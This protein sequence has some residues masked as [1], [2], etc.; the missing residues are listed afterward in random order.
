[1]FIASGLASASVL[2]ILNKDHL[3][4]DSTALNFLTRFLKAYLQTESIDHLSSSLRKGGVAD[5]MQFFPPARQSMA[6]LSAH[7]KAE[8]LQNV[9]D[10]Y[11]KQKSGQAKEETLFK[12][13]EMV[14]DE[15]DNDEVCPPCLGLHRSISRN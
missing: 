3:I 4:K 15:T 7:F 2:A 14:V 12:L 9:L 5:L 1:M 6:E 10:F 13:K 8:G 11:T